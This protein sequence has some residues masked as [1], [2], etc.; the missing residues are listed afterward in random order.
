MCRPI[1]S[2][3]ADSWRNFSQLSIRVISL[4]RARRETLGNNSYEDAYWIRLLQLPAL[5]NF[6]QDLPA[7]G[8]YQEHRTEIKIDAL[9]AGEYALV[10][11]A[12]PGF[13]LNKNPLAVQFIYIS[14]IASVN[15]YEIPART[16]MGAV[17]SMPS[18]MA[19]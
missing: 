17:F 5:K 2:E 11:S 1:E 15:A 4:D 7:T 19:I 10:A 13:E 18:F 6:S 8:D 9:P 12:S 14:S 16:R 3:T